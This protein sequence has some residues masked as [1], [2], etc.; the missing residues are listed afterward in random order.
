MLPSVRAWLAQ[1]PTLVDSCL[2]ALLLIASL[3]ERL[4]PLLNGNLPAGEVFLAVAMT[5]PLALRRRYPSAVFAV[6][7]LAGFAQWLTNITM[8]PEDLALL[9]AC[10]T[11]AAHGRRWEA[12]AATGVVLTGVV[13]AVA[14]WRL[15][16]TVPA[17]VALS[18]LTV[19]ALVLGDDL[20]NRRAYLAALEERAKRLELERDAET[21]A[22]VV[23]ERATIA[24]ELHDIVAHHLSVMVIQSEA[25][26]YAIDADPERARAAM[27]A[28]TDTGRGALTEMRH[29][30][31]VLRPDEG[32]GRVPQ[33]GLD[34]LD[35]LIDG[36]RHAGLPVEFHIDE[37]TRPV[38]A[39]VEVALY[40]IVQEALTNALKHAGHDAHATVAVT[41]DDAAVTALVRDDGQGSAST[42][43]VSGGQGLVGMRERAEL[44]N[45]QLAAGLRPEGGFE[46]SATFPLGAPA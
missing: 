16:E 27:A 6:I 13:M 5:A 7:A 4:R 46:V 37:P 35:A 36:V 8:R 1:R 2:A 45:G 39:G 23:A 17:F 31:G 26:T 28:V 9:I 34:E 25:A 14:R 42:G 30:L 38:T 22:A 33:P 18:A 29:L 44:F 40:R 21:R 11:V 10:Y 24:R 19:A 3:S 41:F 43:T 12:L 20:R 32:Q 15:G